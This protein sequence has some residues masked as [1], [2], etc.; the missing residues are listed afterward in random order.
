[1]SC[2]CNCSTDDTTIKFIRETT[3]ALKFE[4]NVS[5]LSSFY[6]VHFTIRKDYKTAPI[7][8]K[9]ITGLSGDS[10]SIVLKPEDTALFI[11]S[12]FQNGK[13]SLQYIWGLD[14]IVNNDTPEIVNIFPETGKAAPLCIVYKNVVE[15]E[16]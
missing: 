8:D 11:D 2:K 4:F 15:E 7:I 9:T 3:A 12:L 16:E 1:M 10:V 13:N 14:L 6:G 5:D